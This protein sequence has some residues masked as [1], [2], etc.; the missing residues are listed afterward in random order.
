MKIL[1]K[2]LKIY[3]KMDGLWMLRD[4]KYCI[5]QIVADII[6][7]SATI[8]AMIILSIQFNG[9]GG[10][11]HY[12]TMLM[13]G[14]ATN[15]QGLYNL[16][17]ANYNNGMVSR[18]I[19]RGQIEHYMVQPVP[20][21]IQ[22]ATRGF[23]PFSAN[24]QF[25]ISLVL[26]VYSMKELRILTVFMLMIVML[27]SILSTVTMTSVIYIISTIAFYSPSAGEEISQPILALFVNTSYFPIV[28]MN[29]FFRVLYVFIF[30]IGSIAWLPTKMIVEKD[31]IIIIIFII[32]PLVLLGLANVTF[33]KGL[34]Y[35]AKKGAGRY[36]SFG[37]R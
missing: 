9:L 13:F 18:I 28:K 7:V 5:L 8:I 3:A 16:F 20:I 15:V 37:H 24:S 31:K 34:D 27:I 6:S 26:I 29:V 19:G 33:R 17:F 22:I 2:S 21:W 32:I 10:L 12:Q 14:I 4:T 11:T 35:Y 25:L 1:L 36:S 30:P 23:A